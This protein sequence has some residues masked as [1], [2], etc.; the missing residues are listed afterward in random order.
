MFEFSEKFSSK[1]MAK[2]RRR[3]GVYKIGF[4]GTDDFYIGSS[5]DIG[6]RLCTHLSTFKTRRQ[7]NVILIN[8]FN[9]YGRDN[10]YFQVFVECAPNE[11]LAI[12][13]F[14]IDELKPRYNTAK[15]VY[16]SVVS[17][18]SKED[19]I[20][21]RRMYFT[22]NVQED[23]DEIANTYNLSVNY[24]QK[25]ASGAEFSDVKNPDWLNEL[26]VKGKRSPKKDQHTGIDG[27]VPSFSRRKLTKEQ[28]GMI[29]WVIA[30]NKSTRQLCRI[31]G[32]DSSSI[33]KRIKDNQVY[34]EFQDLVDASHLN[35]DDAQ[36]Q[37]LKDSD[38]PKIRWAHLQGIP[39]RQISN[40]FGCHYNTSCD[41]KMNRVYKEIK[42]I[43]PCPQLFN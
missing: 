26:I 5:V 18:L 7:T 29:R 28:V 3:C 11:R 40:V 42:D 17:K 36:V 27:Y 33:I 23:I 25:I 21:I 35:L 8:A 31:F 34:K 19:V 9:K 41:I 39:H 12:E 24:V 43:E 1:E 4:N 37:K 20:N 30:N 16:G 32:M 13:Q 38:I 6:G 2:Y 22:R 10:V 15:S 14:C